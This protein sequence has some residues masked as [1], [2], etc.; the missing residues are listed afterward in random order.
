MARIT[1]LSLI[2]LLLASTLCSYE[3]IGNI[4]AE[5]TLDQSG[6]L[7]EIFAENNL[8]AEYALLIAADGIAVFISE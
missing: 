7:A 5:L 2:L 1:L 3:I 8:K 4:G 6:T